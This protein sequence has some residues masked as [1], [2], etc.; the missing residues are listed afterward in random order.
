[1]KYLTLKILFIIANI[2]INYKKIYLDLIIIKPF[3]QYL[4]F[5]SS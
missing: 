3:E 2:V 5:V 4:F 1:M